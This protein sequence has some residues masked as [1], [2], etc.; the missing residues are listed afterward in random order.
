M[1]IDRATLTSIPLHVISAD[2]QV[3]MEWFVHRTAQ[4]LPGVFKLAF[5][6]VLLV[7]TSLSEPAV[8]HAVLSL[9]SIHRGQALDIA[10]A[11][12]NRGATTGI[13][14]LQQYTRAITDLRC[15]M[16]DKSKL[17]TKVALITCAIFIQLEYLR[18]FYKTALTHLRHGLVM[19][20][21][22]LRTN[23]T[24]EDDNQDLVNKWIMQT[25][26]TMVVQAKIFGQDIYHPHLFSLIGKRIRLVSEIFQSLSHAR[27]SL[28][29]MFLRIMGLKSEHEQ[30][31]KPVMGNQSPSSELRHKEAC[32]SIQLDL[33]MWLR[34]CERVICENEKTVPQ[35][36]ASAVDRFAWKLLRVYHTLAQ[37]M[38]A[39]CFS[40]GPL[41][42]YTWENPS[43]LIQ[44]STVCSSFSAI[45]PYSISSAALASQQCTNGRPHRSSATDNISKSIT[46]LFDSI[47]AQCDVLFKMAFS[48]FIEA[49]GL[50]QHP[51]DRDTSHAIA[52][53]GWIPPIYYASIRSREPRI[54]SK[55]I[56]MLRLVPHREGIWDSLMAATIAEKVLGIEEGRQASSKQEHDLHKKA[57]VSSRPQDTA[58]VL[59]SQKCRL[60]DVRVELPEDP[61][62]RLKLSYTVSRNGDNG[63]N[64]E[65]HLYDLRSSAWNKCPC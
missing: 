58:S 54:R 48:P 11:S 40:S 41:A 34:A 29:R 16:T 50:H 44:V 52:D 51:A 36:A 28:E 55:A 25:F 45:C 27:Q 3:Y 15:R 57:A 23:G 20:E 30:C 21:E 38:A 65:Q 62:G 9:G 39:E 59:E 1:L 56:Q 26:T 24:V 31:T 60:R 8:L 14:A 7:Q 19:L 5:W 37:I 10:T 18:G 43:S 49:S 2:E 47:V 53:I 32:A 35:S 61:D 4:K 12:G 17:S 13:F 46:P 64:L 42:T 33:D 63:W 6:N 22:I